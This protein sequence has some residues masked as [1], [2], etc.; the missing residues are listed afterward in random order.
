MVDIEPLFQGG[1]SGLG[2]NRRSPSAPCAVLFFA[3][4]LNEFSTG[5]CIMILA[6]ERYIL[7]CRPFDAKTYLRQRNRL[8]IYLVASVF[9]A[10]CCTV[11]LA[12]HKSSHISFGLEVA[13]VN[14]RSEF[15]QKFSFWARISVCFVIPAA[16]SAG[17]YTRTIIVLLESKHHRE[18]N[19]TLIKAFCIRD[20]LCIEKL[21]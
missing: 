15:I 1:K 7:T 18:R 8:L 10:V 21:I 9:I 6:I 3:F 4:R 20:Q 5:I 17:L 12:N 2:T 11:F 14:I 13:C 19:R 16:I